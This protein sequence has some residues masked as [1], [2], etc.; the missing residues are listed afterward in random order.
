[1]GIGQVLLEGNWSFYLNQLWIEEAA[2]IFLEERVRSL[3]RF[4]AGKVS[5]SDID[6]SIVEHLYRVGA[7]ASPHRDRRVGRSAL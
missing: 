6:L 5:D 4:H 2:V 1:M 7:V 3:P